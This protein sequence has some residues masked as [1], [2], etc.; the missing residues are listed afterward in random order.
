MFQACVCLQV[1]VLDHDF[2]DTFCGEHFKILAALMTDCLQLL[3]VCNLQG[4]QACFQ[5]SAYD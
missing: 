1:I 4:V 3:L 2:G 5:L